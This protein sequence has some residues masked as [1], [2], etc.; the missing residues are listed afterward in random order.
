MYFRVKQYKGLLLKYLKV[1]LI[2]FEFKRQ[3]LL[4]R[5]KILQL[6]QLRLQRNFKSSIM[7]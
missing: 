7:V 5:K 2:S 1:Y 3:N 4:Y 6:N